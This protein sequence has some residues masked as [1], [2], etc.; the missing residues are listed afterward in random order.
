MQQRLMVVVAHPDDETFGCGSTLLHAAA[1]GVE[2]AVVCATRGEAGEPA[3]DSGVT[4]AELGAVRERELHEAA[5]LLGVSSVQL[6]DYADSGMAGPTDATTLVGAS[7]DDVV[8]DVRARLEQFKPH[9]VVTL[10]AADGHRDHERIRDATLAAVDDMRW[11]VERVYLQCLSRELMQ[12]WLD[13]ARVAD[14]DSPY[15]T[16]PGTPDADLTTVIDSAA[17][18]PQRER[19]IAAHRSQVA[20]FEGLPPD[21]Y[22][23]FLTVERLQRVRPPVWEGGERETGLF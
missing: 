2:T 9:V 6:L 13:H 8:D 23:D 3:P 5:A 15:L 19:A 14:P 11:K 10:D 22:R 20:P 18:L 12:R 4:V 1:A 16:A 7:F 17:L 21:L